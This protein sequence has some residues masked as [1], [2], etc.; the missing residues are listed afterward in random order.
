MNMIHITEKEVALILKQNIETNNVRELH[1]S[2]YKLCSDG[3][4]KLNKIYSEIMHSEEIDLEMYQEQFLETLVICISEKK[5]YVKIR[6]ERYQK[7]VTII[8]K[9]L[10]FY[11]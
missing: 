10:N 9:K 5:D 11:D 2:E 7:L 3:I 4:S 8:A 6:M 1:N